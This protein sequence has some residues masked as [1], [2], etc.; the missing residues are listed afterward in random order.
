M[1]RRP[2]R[3]TRTDTLFPYTTLFRSIAAAGDGGPN[4]LTPGANRT[5]S[6]DC[7]GWEGRTNVHHRELGKRAR[8]A[9]QRFTDQPRGI[10]IR[11]FCT[12]SVAAIS[13]HFMLLFG[14]KDNSDHA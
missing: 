7:E 6:F 2:P 1:I 5:E 3:S 9:E 11:P 13:T 14:L 8:R 10:G 12:N 4:I